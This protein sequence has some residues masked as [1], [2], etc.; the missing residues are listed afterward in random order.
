MTLS[1]VSMMVFLYN[2][3][4]A[5]GLYVST[6]NEILSGTDVVGYGSIYVNAHPLNSNHD[7]TSI[8]LD[9]SGHVVVT[10][11]DDSS[12]VVDVT[13]TNARLFMVN[14]PNTGAIVDELAICQY[15]N[16]L[17]LVAGDETIATSALNS[18]MT[19]DSGTNAFVETN[20]CS[21]V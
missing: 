9:S 21:I 10:N 20:I 1:L 8:P 4:I 12:S 15:D 17:V 13:L 14:N 16:T 11:V 19:Y 6:Q 3:N 18:Q 2:P 5:G 7:F